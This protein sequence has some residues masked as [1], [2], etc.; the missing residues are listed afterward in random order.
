LRA[1]I[2]RKPRPFDVLLVDDTSRLCRNLGE[3]SSFA[4]E[5]RFLGLR[6]I[7]V[8]QGIDTQNKQ[9]KVL[10]TFHGL[11]DEMYIE[12]L[13]SKTHR[14]LEGRALN[15][16]NTGGRTYGYD[17]V[18]EPNV[19]G[20]DGIPA[21]RKQVNPSEAAVL[22]RIFEMYA[23]G[24]S[25]S[26]I[27]KTLNSERIPPPRKRKGR[28]H[29]PTWCPTAIREMLRRDIYIGR[30]VWN[31]REF[32][33][34]PNTNKRVSRPRPEDQW[35]KPF[36]VPD[37]RIIDDQLWTR[38]QSRLAIV[39]GKYNFKGRP[40]LA[41]RASTSPN[42]LTG[43]LKC[44]VCG[45]NLTVVTGRAKD[46]QGRYGC[47]INFKR[48]A[49]TNDVKQRADEIEVHLLSE[50]Q[51]EVLSPEAIDYAVREFERQLQSS[52]AGLD[53]RIGR[54]RQ[55]ADEL[56]REI[57]TAVAN[58]IACKNNPALVEAINTRQREYDEITRQL[59]STEP[60]SIPAEIGRIRQF[61]THQLD[62]IRQLLNVDVQKAKK[63][64]E[65][66]VT[67]IRMVPHKEGKNGHYIA[68]GQWN[69]LGGYGEET[70]NPTTKRI[71]MV[72]G[73]GFEPSTFGL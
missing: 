9:A 73:E 16:L 72:A 64:L 37:L 31:R 52:L 59:L 15:G 19:V 21:R 25:Y 5:A 35:T 17:N 14:G 43:F 41:H 49:C 71:R 40:G 23:D 66:H 24:H 6:V 61:V 29:N 11:A 20:A 22:R 46:G 2:N 39:G 62:D 8:S 42:L 38:V 32:R 45:H 70:G 34:R 67:S 33:K 68:E 50:W 53:T 30:I 48:G 63:I 55:R 10:M 18:P 47:P 65:Q 56:K 28:D 54:M 26:A 3:N 51:S 12:E 1:A 69:L 60:D 7:A 27:A 4:D 58:L 13:A 57:E 36:E 44:G